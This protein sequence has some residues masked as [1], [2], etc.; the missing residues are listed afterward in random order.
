MKEIGSV[1]LYGSLF[2]SSVRLPTWASRI[3]GLG[4][5]RVVRVGLGKVEIG[6]CSVYVELYLVRSAW[7]GRIWHGCRG[8]GRTGSGVASVVAW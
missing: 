3:G 2:G 7:V 8:C 6:S 5:L 4:G 1:P